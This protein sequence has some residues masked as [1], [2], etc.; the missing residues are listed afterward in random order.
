MSIKVTELFLGRYISFHDEVRMKDIVRAFERAVTDAGLDEGGRFICITHST[1]GPVAREWWRRYYQ[2]TGTKQCPMSHLIMLAPANFGSALAVLG[3]GKLSRMSSWWSNVEPGQ[4]VLDWLV[5]GSAEAWDLNLDWIQNGSKHIGPNGVFPFVLTGESIDRKFYD[6]LNSYTGELGSDGVVRVSAANLRGNYVRLVQQAPEPVPGK[7]GKFQAPNL[8]VDAKATVLAPPTPLR[9]LAGKS[10]S[11]NSMGI[12]KSVKAEVGT[13]KDQATVDA[14]FRCMQVTS[15]ADY[16]AVI[17]DFEQETAQVQAEQRLEIEERWLRSPTYF[18]HDQF[19]MM[20]FRVKDHDGFPVTDFDILLTGGEH[21]D[22]N[23]LPKGFFA[24][25]QLNNS[26]RNTVTYY[27]NH[28]VMAGCEAVIDPR[29][30]AVVREKLEGTTALGFRIAARPDGGFTRYL[31][32]SL[33]AS[34]AM[35]QQVVDAN[36]T[37]LIDIV[38][39]RVVGEETVRFDRGVEPQSFKTTKPG[40]PLGD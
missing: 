1:G 23:H 13:A 36:N 3:K 25:R 31:P 28:S 27:V 11:G 12:M 30:G 33:S 18:I 17:Q 24:D 38:L 8:Q 21:D 16:Q 34:A 2:P 35:L 7:P 15:K 20:I 22:P 10:H 19:S 32:C 26:S 37:T 5:L 6:N 29:D 9:V 4:G 40:D 14:I 39:R